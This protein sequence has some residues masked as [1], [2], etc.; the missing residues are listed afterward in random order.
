MTKCRRNQPRRELP[1]PGH[2]PGRRSTGF[3][4]AGR[5]RGLHRRRSPLRA[6]GALRR[7]PLA[8]RTLAPVV[9]EALAAGE[10]TLDIAK[11]FGA[12]SSQEIQA[13]VFEQASSAYYAP[14]PDSIRRMVLSGTVRAA[15]RAPGSSAAMPMSRPAAAS[16]VNCSTT[17]TASPGSMWRLLE[18]LARL[19]WKSRPRR[20]P[21]S[22]AS[23]G[24]AHARSYASHDLVDGLV[25]LSAEPAPLTEAELARLEALD[26]SWDEHAAILEDED[27]AEEAVPRPKPRSK[28]SSASAGSFATAPVLA[29]ELKAEAGMILALARRHAGAPAGLL[30]RTPCRRRSRGRGIEI[31]PADAGEGGRR[32]ALSKRLVDELAMQRRDILSLHI[33]SDPG[34]A[35]DLMVFTLA[36]ADTH[37]WRSRASTTLR[38]GACQGRSSASKPRMPGERGSGRTHGRSRR[39]LAGRRG[40]VGAVRLFPGA[41]R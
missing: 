1:P 18:S 27:S 22:R 9:F 35:L 24:S 8:S 37:D 30:W 34:L 21:P 36:D 29:P 33:A 7:G 15:I 41:V 16:N 14:S 17:M 4:V 11:A 28:R 2:E 23:P 32:S 26:A 20:S 6:Y 25:R 31:V 38:G 13:R 40:R 10:I 3:R 39:E 12:T 19:G 5:Q